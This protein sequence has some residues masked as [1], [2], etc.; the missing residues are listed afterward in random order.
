MPTSRKELENA[1]AKKKNELAQIEATNRMAAI[2]IIEHVKEEIAQGRFEFLPAGSRN[3]TDK[4][5]TLR[6]DWFRVVI[7]ADVWGWTPAVAYEMT[8]VIDGLVIIVTSYRHRA[9]ND[10]QIV[11]Y[12]YITEF[13]M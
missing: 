6:R 8:R 12:G 10:P 1:I 7:D 5:D 11:V 4:S 2:Q 3:P 13:G 9:V